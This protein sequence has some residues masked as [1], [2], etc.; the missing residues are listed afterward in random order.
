[1][2]RRF[3]IFILLNVAILDASAQVHKKF[4]N[5]DG[6]ETKDST[7]AVSYM[8][9]RKEGQDSLWSAVILDMHN[10]PI[11]K[12]VY[13]DDD[14]TI[15]YGKFV[16]YQGV[17]DQKKIDDHHSS[18][19]TVI[20]VR[21]TG[22]YINGRKEG[23][24]IDYFPNG[25]KQAIRIFEN[26]Q[27]NGLFEEYDDQGK[28]F[29]RSN[30]INGVREGDAF[31]F[32]S[33][34]SVQSYNKFWHGTSIDSKEYSEKDQMYNAYPGFDFKYHIY[35]YLKK[36][37]LPPAHG[38]VIIAFTIGADGKLANPEIKMGVD[39]VL[40]EAIIEALNSSPAWVPAKLNKKRI[41][42]KLTLGFEYDTPKE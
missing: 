19:D 23:V 2:M 42:Q 37:G 12:G 14:L 29:S 9:Y 32:R 27:L 26:N 36:L 7:K 31:I 18:I 11:M 10:F 35:K 28:I 20:K 39:P 6:K 33:D 17:L 4:F 22:F 38:N 5:K 40:D 13:L 34:S 3:L 15:P 8:L 16:Y 21:R 25:A 30:Y 1:M 24:W 41:E